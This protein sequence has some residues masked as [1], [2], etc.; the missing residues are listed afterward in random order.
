MSR[1][2]KVIISVV[3]AIVLLTVGITVPVMGQEDSTPAPEAEAKGLLAR[4]AEILDNVSQEAL[5]NAFKQAQ[6]ELRE[7][8]FLK[9]I[10]K[11]A[12]KD[13]IT[14]KEAE[15]I[16]VWWGQRPEVLKRVPLLP[17]SKA[18]RQA[19]PAGPGQDRL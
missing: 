13:I 12:E 8:A 6:Q 3:V 19:R 15:E 2:I 9:A 16:K 1:K 4:V 11:A 7:E 14:P 5:V 17:T 18:M 10:D